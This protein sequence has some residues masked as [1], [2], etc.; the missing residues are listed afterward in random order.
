MYL[1]E[2]RPAFE[3][4]MR[5]RIRE[6]S[7]YLK[8]SSIG[9]WWRERKEETPALATV[10]LDDLGSNRAELRSYGT[11]VAIIDTPPFVPAC[12]ERVDASKNRWLFAG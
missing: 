3:S 1:V 11:A 12:I 9:E 10:N 7:E 4:E 2:E 6:R 5:Q 8:V